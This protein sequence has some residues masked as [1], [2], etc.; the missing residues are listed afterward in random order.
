MR[1]EMQK[2][3]RYLKDQECPPAVHDRVM[4]RIARQATPRRSF[5]PLLAGAILSQ[6]VQG[7]VQ[8]K[9]ERHAHSVPAWQPAVR[10]PRRKKEHP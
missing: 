7:T 2:L 10:A 3:I 9:I 6:L 4:E 8:T 5:K 1:P